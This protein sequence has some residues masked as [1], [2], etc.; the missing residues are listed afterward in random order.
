MERQ[1]KTS[2]QAWL[3]WSEFLHSEKFQFYMKMHFSSHGGQDIMGLLGGKLE[4]KGYQLPINLVRSMGNSQDC[5]FQMGER[6][7]W[8]LIS[9]VTNAPWQISEPELSKRELKDQRVGKIQ[10]FMCQ[11]LIVPEWR[12]EFTHEVGGWMGHIAMPPSSG[13]CG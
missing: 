5:C 7:L 1:K 9:P 8:N 4:Y 6:R 11:L 13:S 12:C 10:G 2:R 3:P